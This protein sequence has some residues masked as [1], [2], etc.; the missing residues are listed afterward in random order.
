MICIPIQDLIIIV[1]LI[2]AFFLLGLIIGLINNPR[3]KK[4]KDK[5]KDVAKP[6]YEDEHELHSPPRDYPKLDS[7]KTSSKEN[8]QSRR[9]SRNGYYNR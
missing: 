7:Q 3:L 8:G 5:T 4:D 6:I 9:Y 2:I 1:F